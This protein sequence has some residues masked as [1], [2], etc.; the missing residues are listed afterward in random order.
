MIVWRLAAC[1][2]MLASCALSSAVSV[3]G[4]PSDLKR[5]CSCSIATSSKSGWR[6]PACFVV[7]DVSLACYMVYCDDSLI[8]ALAAQGR[9][10]SCALVYSCVSFALRSLF[11]C[12][13]LL[14]GVW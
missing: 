10:C 9:E 3:R 7:P 8:G 12:A 11:W 13:T 1:S 4:A 14:C 5:Q 6:L 2:V